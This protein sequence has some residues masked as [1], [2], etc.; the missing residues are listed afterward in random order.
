MGE[1]KAI[2]IEMEQQEA[3][4]PRPYPETILGSEPWNGQRELGCVEESDFS[5]LYGASRMKARILALLRAES[6]E[7]HKRGLYSLVE[8]WRLL[9][10]RIEELP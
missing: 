3:M 7:Y 5:E 1:S 4:R 8:H 6:A 9:I 2:L 10:E